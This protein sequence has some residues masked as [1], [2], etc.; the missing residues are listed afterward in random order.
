MTAGEKRTNVHDVGIV[1]MP[2]SFEDI[3]MRG[4]SAHAPAAGFLQACLVAACLL[5]PQALVAG[6][7]EEVA[8]DWRGI[9]E[10][11]TGEATVRAILRAHGDGFEIDISLP[12]APP[13][14]AQLVPSEERRVFEVAA[15]RRGLFGFFNGGDRSNP[16]DGEPLIWARSSA[17]GIVAY[18]LTIGAD[19][20]M[21][22]LRIAFE[23]DGE[24]LEMAVERRIDAEPRTRFAVLLERSG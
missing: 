4:A 10:V 12:E 9:V 1:I 15:A 14:R 24:R 22:L 7:P 3:I 21:T 16:F 18:R 23:P 5:W 19:G 8:G 17:L 13:L 6:L 2:G 11:E 20:G